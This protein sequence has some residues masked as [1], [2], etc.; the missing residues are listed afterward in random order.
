MTDQGIWTDHN[1]EEKKERKEKKVK[2]KARAKVKLSRSLAGE[3]REEW[4]LGTSKPC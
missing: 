3:E 4:H 1:W 2:K